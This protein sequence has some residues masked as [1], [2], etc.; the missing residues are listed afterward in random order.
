MWE[1]PRLASKRLESLAY[2]LKDLASLRDLFSELNF[3]FADEPIDKDSWSEEERK[4]VQEARV[5]ASKNDY[6]ICHIQTNTDS[7]KE[8]KGVSSKIIKDSYG[9]CM[10]CSHNPGGFKWVFSSLSKEFSK[11]FSETRHVPIDITP[12]GGVP[13]T[14][15]DFLENIRIS[16]DSA[17]KSIASQVSA[18]FD[19]FAIQI[20]DELTVN[21]FEALKILSEGIILDKSNS[22]ALNARTLEEIRESTFIL[23]YRI[24]FVLYAEDRSVFPDTKFYH[25]YFSIRW[26]KSNWILRSPTLDEYKV[27]GRLKKLF[28]LIEVGSEELDYKPEE[29]F[30]R[31]YYGRLFD[32]KIHHKL[33]KW[34][35]PNK[36]L[37][38]AIGLLTRTKDKKGNYFFLDYAA[39]ETRH[40]GA[41]YEHLL[42]YH[43]IVKDGKIVDLPNPAKRKSTG[44]YYTPKY[45]VD[46]IVANTI[47]PLIDDIVKKTGD[48]GEQI[49]KILDL[50]VLDPAMGSGHFLVGA[51]TYMAQRICEIECNGEIDE[52]TFVERKRDVA[53][54]CIYGVDLNPLA[55]DLAQVSLWLETLSST[56]PLS[57]LSAHLKAGNSLIGSNIDDILEKQ[58]TLME[59]T[60]SRAQ[61]KKTVRDFIM[62]ERLEDDTAAAVKTKVQKYENIRKRG[63][64]HYTLKFLL[65]AKTAKHFSIDT[66]PLGDYVGKI[67]ENSLNFHEEDGIWQQVKEASREHSFFHWDLEFPNIFYNESGKRKKDPGFDAVIGNPPYVNIENLSDKMRKYYLTNYQACEKRT[68]IYIAFLEKSLALLNYGGLMCFII[69]SAFAKQKYGM[70]M[71]SVLINNHTIKTLVDVSNYHIFDH[72]SVFNIIITICK[73]KKIEQTKVFQFRQQIDFESNCGTDFSVNQQLFTMLKDY[74]FDTNPS[75]VDYI[76]IKK[77]IWKKSIA[78]NRICLVAYGARLNHRSKNIGKSNYLKTAPLPNLKKFCEGRNIQRYSFSQNGWLKYTPNEHYN[79]MFKELFENPKLMCINVVK[80]R[81]RSAYDDQEFYN[82]HTVINCVRLDLLTRASHTSAI[83]AVKGADTSVSKQF[84]YKFLLAVLNSQLINWYF[85]NFLSEDLHFYPNDAKELP[86]PKITTTK[87]NAF[88]DLIKHI[89]LSKE[90]D[91][92]ADTEILEKQIDRLIYDFYG[93]TAKE[94]AVVEKQLN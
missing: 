2:G 94:I 54:R 1:D 19:S 41:I 45:V 32:R 22:L 53:R 70:K 89:M 16:E 42:E 55:V 34:S 3:N 64:I 37:L 24:M 75:I 63:T 81:L 74:R 14:F 26:I 50:N 39:L 66:P 60:R 46:Y 21:V 57:F 62:L 59:S 93:L 33:E 5:I 87:Q 17:A 49:D 28:R 13:K 44:S 76:K 40:L 36:N 8:W 51:T 25:E 86:I 52:E 68:D 92:T 43:L 80:D 6:R 30:M 29:F 35:V 61:F 48:L 12:S 10:V 15:V 58:T 38:D 69:P 77:K 9:L 88:V 71:R 78:L 73:E 20:H 85:I 18:A 82:S 65:D 67:G 90:S 56:K 72:V 79:P 83:R 27:Y 31:S 7:V 47:G 23:L 91:P 4:M 11:S 84:T